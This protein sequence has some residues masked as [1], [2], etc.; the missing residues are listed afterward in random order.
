MS[1]DYVKAVL[2][3]S[4]KI[5]TVRWIDLRTSVIT[6]CCGRTISALSIKRAMN[7]VPS[8][9]TIED[10]AFDDVV[11]RIVTLCGRIQ[12]FA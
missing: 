10:G 7:K 5:H 4:G 2:T 12:E 8:S 11:G 3:R 9:V 6:A 1:N